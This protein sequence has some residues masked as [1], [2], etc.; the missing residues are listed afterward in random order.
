MLG[1]RA[2]SELFEKN[3]NMVKIEK[4]GIGISLK[5]SITAIKMSCKWDK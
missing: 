2:K 5:K 4:L 3:E 1:L